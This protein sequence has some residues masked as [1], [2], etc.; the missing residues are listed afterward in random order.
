MGQRAAF[1]HC[2][3]VP[4]AL[5]LLVLITLR[6]KVVFCL[7]IS[8]PGGFC[9]GEGL[10]AAV[11]WARALEG[12]SRYIRRL[13]A[14]FP[15]GRLVFPPVVAPVGL[16]ELPAPSR[17]LPLRA[18]VAGPLFIRAV[19]AARHL[20]RRAEALVLLEIRVNELPFR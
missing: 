8:L 13:R 19:A 5:H 11:P 16:R 15:H 1:L 10:E 14:P 2:R 3:S 6:R 9:R 20:R 12:R 17:A 4:Q 7:E 18:E